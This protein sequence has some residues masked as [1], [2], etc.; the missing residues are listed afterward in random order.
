MCVCV[1]GSWAQ[2]TVF[3]VFS[4]PGG[5]KLYEFRRGLATNAT[6]FSMAFDVSLARENQ[7]PIIDRSP[8]LPAERERRGEGG[9]REAGLVRFVT[10]FKYMVCGLRPAMIKA[11]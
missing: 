4:M 11:A 6:I 8:I 9:E 5:E 1:V 7:A 3:R 10:H 2:G